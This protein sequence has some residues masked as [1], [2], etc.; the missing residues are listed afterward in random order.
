MCPKSAEEAA[1]VTGM[2]TDE[3]MLTA[4]L[5]LYRNSSGTF[6][7]VSG[8]AAL[9]AAQSPRWAES[10]G[11]PDLVEVAVA[12]AVCGGGAAVSLK[13]SLSRGPHAY[14]TEIRSV[15]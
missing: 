4:Y 15:E 1:L 6:E 7:C 9:S 3:A 10:G 11:E 13:L 8:G 2:F 14:V 12:T 5:G